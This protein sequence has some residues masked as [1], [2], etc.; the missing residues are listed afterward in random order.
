MQ[1]ISTQEAEMQYGPCSRLVSSSDCTTRSTLPSSIDRDHHFRLAQSSLFHWL[2]ETTQSLANVC[3]G[4]I[5]RF[6]TLAE[7]KSGWCSKNCCAAQR[8]D[9][10]M[11]LT[12]VTLP[13]L[14]CLYF[15]FVP[16]SH[17][18]DSSTRLL[19]INLMTISSIARTLRSYGNMDRPVKSA[20]V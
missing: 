14:S 8:Y 16:L 10:L 12:L 18:Y 7:G 5:Y 9:M 15:F 13:G 2:R 20:S 19:R 11:M 6:L 3:K 1:P 17:R 4:C